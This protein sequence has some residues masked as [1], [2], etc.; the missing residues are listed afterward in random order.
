MTFGKCSGISEIFGKWSEKFSQLCF[1]RWFAQIWK[2]HLWALCH[3]ITRYTSPVF[4]RLAI[5]DNW[6]SAVFAFHVPTL[7]W[8][9]WPLRAFKHKSTYFQSPW[10]RPGR[11]NKHKHKD[12]NFP[13][14]A[15]AFASCCVKTKRSI[16]T[17]TRARAPLPEKIARVAQRWGVDAITCL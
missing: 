16:S 5:T 1:T 7:C 10:K 2:D 14:F 11:K 9:I 12:R 4:H 8:K 3:A 17:S 13:S 6:T 15:L